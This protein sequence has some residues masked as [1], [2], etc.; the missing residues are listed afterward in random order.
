MPY[1]INAYVPPKEKRPMRMPSFI[2][3]VLCAACV[4]AAGVSGEYLSKD[5]PEGHGSCSGVFVGLGCLLLAF[6]FGFGTV[7]NLVRHRV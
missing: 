7:R 2:Y 3:A 4:G 5:L 6:Y 1:R